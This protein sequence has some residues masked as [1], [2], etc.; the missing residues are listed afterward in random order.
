MTE[1]KF[2][3]STKELIAKNRNV[4]NRLLTKYFTSNFSYNLGQL[5]SY[6]GTHFRN[7]A[8]TSLNKSLSRLKSKYESGLEYYFSHLELALD[9]INEL[10][11]RTD[12]ATNNELSLFIDY[13]KLKT[14]ELLYIIESENEN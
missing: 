11:R 2:K 10:G 9:K 8:F 1:Q 3:N 13:F 4:S 14:I 12:A 5:S 6:D 7:A